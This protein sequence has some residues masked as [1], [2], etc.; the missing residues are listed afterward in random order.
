VVNATPGA[1]M[2]TAFDDTFARGVDLTIRVRSDKRPQAGDQFAMAIARWVEAD[3]FYTC[4]AR[5]D[6]QGRFWVQS[7]AASEGGIVRLGKEVGVAGLQQASG[8]DVWLRCQVAGVNP[9]TVRMKSWAGDQP[10]PAEWLV[11]ET[12]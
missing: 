7:S 11:N 1:T 4:Q 6:E 12:D 9:T 3:A 8:A 5:F 10:E 2:T